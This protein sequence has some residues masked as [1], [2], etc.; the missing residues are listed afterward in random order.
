M[1]TTYFPYPK[2]AFQ[3]DPKPRLWYAEEY[4]RLHDL[5]FFLDQRVELIGGVIIGFDSKNPRPWTADEFYR[6]LDLGFFQGQRVELIEGI[7]LQMAAQKNFHLAA[8]TKTEYALAPVF[9]SGYWIRAQGS[10]DLSPLS[11]PDPDIAVIKG[12]PFT[13]TLQ[14]PKSAL[15]VVEVSDTTLAS[16]QGNKGSLYSASGIADYWI[17]NLVDRQVEVYR[18][19]VP[20]A[21]EVF[22]WRYDHVQFFGPGEFVVPL[23]APQSKVAVDDLLP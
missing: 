15:L 11:V 23:A 17:I 1:T 21:S 4:Y 20:D 10:L 13:P 14:N 22:G 16:D 7:I 5:G 8:I 18:N 9:G 2:W 12:S 6:L 19:P 3:V